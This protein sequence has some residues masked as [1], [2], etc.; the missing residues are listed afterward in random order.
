M[1]AQHN[2]GNGDC[3]FYSVRDPLFAY[4][5]SHRKQLHE[6]LVMLGLKPTDPVAFSQ[7]ALRQV[8]YTCF[9]LP[10]P[11]TEFIMDQ[12]KKYSAFDLEMAC[13]FAHVAPL[14]KK[15]MDEV[16]AADRRQVFLNCMKN[17]TWGD[18]TVLNLLE[19][20]L[21]VRFMVV[22][23]KKLAIRSCDH[24]D[25]FVPIVYI[26]LLMRGE[27]YQ[28]ITIKGVGAFA[29]SELPSDLVDLSHRDCYMAK[30]PYINLKHLEGS[31]KKYPQ[32][33][34]PAADSVSDT[35][36]VRPTTTA[37]MVAHYA[38]CVP[39][40]PS[41]VKIET[42]DED[43]EE[44]PDVAFDIGSASPSGITAHSE[45]F[46]SCPCSPIGDV[47]V[48]EDNYGIGYNFLALQ[49]LH[50]AAPASRGSREEHTV[51]ADGGLI[52]PGVLPSVVHR[53]QC[54]VTVRSVWRRD[55]QVAG[56]GPIATV[57]PNA[58]RFPLFK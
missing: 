42:L 56:P 5:G 41:T 29:E 47:D 51:L 21:R 8:A 4:N 50:G 38:L 43:D 14:A 6:Q 34:L 3:L 33:P 30:E 49:S 53:L 54:G 26:P 7:T 19:K 45:N 57:L 58:A 13:H 24:G 2:E 35:D 46:M 25:D 39:H 52:C 22:R 37:D 18:E 44:D 31:G 36:A 40:I 11:F 12:W 1:R 9:L 16:T 17:S 27:H 15:S 32:K 10:H 23:D 55:P 48:Q 28:S 20:L